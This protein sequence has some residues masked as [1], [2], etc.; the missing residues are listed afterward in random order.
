MSY[1]EK[2]FIVCFEGRNFNSLKWEQDMLKFFLHYFNFS[3]LIG[4]SQRTAEPIFVESNFANIYLIE[5]EKAIAK[6]N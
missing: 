4:V 3:D 5:C 6:P 2:C 1:I